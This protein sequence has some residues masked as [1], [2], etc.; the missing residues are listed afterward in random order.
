VIET[1]ERG[2]YLTEDNSCPDEWVETIIRLQDMVGSNKKF[3]ER[4]LE[5]IK[6]QWS[7]VC[8]Y[9]LSYHHE[10]L[11]KLLEK[12]ERIL[13]LNFLFPTDALIKAFN[14]TLKKVTFTNL[15]ETDI[16]RINK[17]HAKLPF[18]EEREEIIAR[19]NS[20]VSL[21]SSTNVLSR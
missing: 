11:H 14:C 9:F 1:L 5:I 19:L 4:Q 10:N 21:G 2:H 16:D 12:L 7:V 15:Y 8:D 17:L 3:S 13:E 18:K 20:E 6:N